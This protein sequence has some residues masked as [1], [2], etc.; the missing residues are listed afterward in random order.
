MKNSIPPSSDSLSAR[1]QSR[2]FRRERRG[3]EEKW[4]GGN[5]TEWITVNAKEITVAAVHNWTFFLTIKEKH[6]A[7]PRDLLSGRYGLDLLLQSG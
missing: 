2:N 7:A 3:S 4:F 5:E 6:R 1:S